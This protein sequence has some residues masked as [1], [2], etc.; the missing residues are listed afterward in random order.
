MRDCIA[1]DVKPDEQPRFG[2]YGAGSA[3]FSEAGTYWVRVPWLPV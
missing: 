1:V 3:V 2:D